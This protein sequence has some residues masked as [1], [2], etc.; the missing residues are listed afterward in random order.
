MSDYLLSPTPAVEMLSAWTPDLS[1]LPDFRDRLPTEE[2][3]ENY[4]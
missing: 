1:S 3:C 4:F 2:F